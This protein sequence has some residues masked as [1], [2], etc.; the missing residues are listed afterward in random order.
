MELDPGGAAHVLD[1]TALDRLRQR[2]QA[3]GGPPVAKPIEESQDTRDIVPQA[4][5]PTVRAVHR[6]RTNTTIGRHS[7]RD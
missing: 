3:L 7:R 5:G 4:V 1:G 6:L 2:L